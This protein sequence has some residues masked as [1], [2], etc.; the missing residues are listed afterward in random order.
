MLDANEENGPGV[1]S[2]LLGAA[3]GLFGGD[4]LS[5]V[6]STAVGNVPALGAIAAGMKAVNAIL[7]GLDKSISAAINMQS[8]YI[9]GINARLNGITDQVSTYGELM[10]DL[11]VFSGSQYVSMKE[12]VKNVSMLTEKGIAYNLEERALLESIR[13]RVV[14]TFSAVEGQLDRLI[15]LQQA[16]LTRQQMG[17]EAELNRML[18]SMFH[19]TSY[20]SDVYDSVSSAI[21]DATSNTGLGYRDVVEFNYNLQKWLGALYSLGMQSST[22]SSIAEAINSLATGNV[23]QL[24]GTPM[25]NLFALSARNANLS[26]TDILTE[27]LN[28]SNINDLMKAMIEYMQQIADNTSG[29][30]AK[31]AILG[32]IGGNFSF[33][34]IRAIS[35]LSTQDINSIYNS[36]QTY[37][38]SAKTLVSEISKLE[39]RTAYETRVNNLL[40]NMLLNIGNAM[41]GD[42]ISTYVA[43]RIS[44][45]LP[46]AIGKIVKV[47]A[48]ITRLGRI[49]DGVL[50]IIQSAGGELS[51]GPQAN[52]LSLMGTSQQINARGEQYVPTSPLSVSEGVSYSA[53]IGSASALAEQRQ[54]SLYQ[55]A[56]YATASTKN[57]TGGESNVASRDI[58]DLYSELFEQQLHPIRVAVATVEDGAK[59]DLGIGFN[60]MLVDVQDN[61]INSLINSVYTVRSSM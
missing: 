28:A 34:D 41:I 21:I 15:R 26:Y 2:R 31:N 1:K 17:A 24:N 52:I 5:K 13:D 39:Q 61:D 54:E 47:V 20:L 9:S 57:I 45:Q 10:Q 4:S 3:S 16:D 44:D 7:G 46:D 55:S 29:N 53:T 36:T 48:G 12:L 60:G 19:D 50:D 27:G 32:A 38:T 23:N 8:Q 42:S 33:S 58:S 51:V 25:G 6:I 59:S 49:V 56:S 18:N 37:D 43:W 40:D 14:T 22:V 35:N 30:V 11:Q